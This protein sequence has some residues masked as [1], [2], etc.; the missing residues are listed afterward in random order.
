MLYAVIDPGE[1]TGFLLLEADYRITPLRIKILK[2]SQ[3]TD[4]NQVCQVL[5]KLVAST[6]PEELTVIYEKFQIQRTARHTSPMEIIGVIKFL[7]LS[8]EFNLVGQLPSAQAA[9][10]HHFHDL[11]I[12]YKKYRHIQSC[13]FHAVFYFIVNYKPPKIILEHDSFLEQPLVFDLLT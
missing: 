7:Q 13:L 9:P 3:I 6:N 11:R 12:Y 5:H 1:T 10:K 4:F 8:Y 2:A